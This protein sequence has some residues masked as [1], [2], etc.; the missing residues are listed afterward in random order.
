LEA[1]RKLSAGR[2][3]TAKRL[4]SA[5]KEELKELAMPE[6]LF[7]VS[8]AEVEANKAS[9]QGM[10][11][12]EFFLASNPGEASRPL[13]RIASGGELSR[14]MLSIKALQVDTQGASTVIF[15]EVDAGIGGHTSSAVGTRLARVALRQQVLCVTHLHQIA[16]RADHHLSV[17]KTVCEGRTHIEVT[18]L[19]QE[20]R[21]E[22]LTRMLGAAPDA[23]SARE[24][25]RKLID[26]RRAEVSG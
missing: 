15:D 1:A 2:R 5:M 25:V 17:R 22:E 4:E 7:S 26:Q 10:D 6:A 12:V 20:A 24:H 19:H 3:D 8:F 16:A 11:K 13:A 14:I 21:V 18:P 23:E 9:G